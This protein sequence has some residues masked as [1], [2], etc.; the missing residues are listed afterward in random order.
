MDT[1]QNQ[2]IDIIRNTNDISQLH[3]YLVDYHE[4][5]IASVFE[6]LS[7]DELK[8][9]YSCF[10]EQELSDIF[11]YI[12]DANL[13]LTDFNK[14]QAADIIELMDSDDALTVLEN[15][16]EKERNEIID[17]IEEE[18]R[19]DIELI[20]SY[21][22]NQIGS[23]MTNNYITI[24]KDFSIRQA[25]KVVIEEAENNDNFTTIYVVNDDD[26]L[27]GTV[28][29]KDLIKARATDNLLDIIKMNYPTIIDT[30][31]VSNAIITLKEYDMD[32]IAVINDKNEFLGVITPNDIVE[33]VDDE[34]SEDYAKLAGLSSE[35]DLDEGIFLSVRKRIPWL[36][37]LLILG[38]FIS[39]VMG[40][41]ESAIVAVP[42]IVFFQSM[43]LGM[44]GNV[45]TQSLAVTIR[46]LSDE[47]LTKS[48]I[49]KLVF[50]EMRIAL[51]NGLFISSIAFAVVFGYLL[52]THEIINVNNGFNIKDLLLTAF[53]VSI[54]LFGT[55]LISGFIG[56]T[57]PIVLKKLKID[58]AVASGPFITTINDITA[59]VIYYG[60]ALLMFSILFCA[61]AFAKAIAS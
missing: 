36:C 32:S 7:D 23:Y 6:F 40:L 5:D 50:K 55:I 56:T 41:F 42:V 25:M 60:I 59:I 61:C 14:E 21:E 51:F 35:E 44:G 34:L 12:E 29:L 38:I 26:T 48:K 4:H 24:K 46:A 45:G 33:V 8:K 43:I 15:F 58:P 19:E 22:D 27:F 52:I 2:I 13:Y 3:D 16:D 54:S 57:T 28:E 31:L 1:L 30:D 17:L 20:D 49:F 53:V 10:N 11:S 37:I 39:I 18:V 47:D 9:I